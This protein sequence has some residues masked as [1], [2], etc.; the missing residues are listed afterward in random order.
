[1]TNV[2][3]SCHS[4]AG[5]AKR[6]TKRRTGPSC[7]VCRILGARKRAKLAPDTTNRVEVEP[8]PQ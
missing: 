2:R 3:T 6:S 5:K 8:T 7:P 4:M 1:M